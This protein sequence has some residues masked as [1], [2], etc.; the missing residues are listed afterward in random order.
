MVQKLSHKIK[1]QDCNRECAITSEKLLEIRLIRKSNPRAKF[2]C[3][4]C[5]VYHKFSTII[6][7]HVTG[8]IEGYRGIFPENCRRY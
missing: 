7:D 4:E 3:N 1:C 2:V 8:E 5:Y 6:I